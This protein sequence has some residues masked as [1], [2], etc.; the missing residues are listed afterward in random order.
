MKDPKDILREVTANTLGVNPG[1]VTFSN[2]RDR[3]RKKK[4]S[5]NIVESENSE[6]TIG[7]DEGFSL[8]NVEVE[9]VSYADIGK[10]RRLKQKNNLE[11]WGA[12]D[13][14]LFAKNKYVEKYGR[15]WDLNIGGS[16]LEI[17]KIRDKFYDLFGFCCNLIMRDYIDFFFDNYIDLM[18][19]SYDSF[20]FSHMSRDKIMCEFCDGYNFSQSFLKYSEGEK[21][22]DKDTI[23]SKEINEAY[24]I[25][26]TSMISNYGIVISFNWLIK[27]KKVL[28]S[29]AA[30]MILS[31]CRDMGAKNMID[32]VKSSTESYS[33]YPN[34]LPFK[35]PQ[36]IIDRIDKNIKLNIEFES[37][38]V[39]YKFL[40]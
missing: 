23:S 4:K 31:A 32:V 5:K 36:K 24:L 25:S 12:F 30:R 13:F 8:T 2:F 22:D 17:N 11:E 40:Q 37:N 38:S 7:N 34:S 26:D 20:Y 18:I 33:P 14:F 10:K 21:E 16:S 9:T 29:D 35:S 6:N 3:K 1:D 39:K 19:Q 27:V 15:K 28:A